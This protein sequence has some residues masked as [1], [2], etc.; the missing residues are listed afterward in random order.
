[1]KEEDSCKVLL[2]LSGGV[3]STA[4]IPFFLDLGCV[5]NPLFIKYGQL[6]QNK[7]LESA[8]KVCNYYKIELKELDLNYDFKPKMGEIVGRNLMF[9]SNAL[10]NINDNNVIGI[11]IHAGTGYFDCSQSFVFKMNE[12]IT[13]ASNG[14]IR[15][16]VPFLNWSK[17]D[18]WDFCKIKSVP[19]HLTYSCEKG[20]KNNC[21]ICNSCIDIKK[22]YEG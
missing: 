16:E 5:I 6:A 14:K 17:G 3:D 1:L 20:M 11:G 18:I 21:G 12:I 22:L 15:L 8:K 7:E 2:L 4:T 9:I 19:V 10:I 13:E